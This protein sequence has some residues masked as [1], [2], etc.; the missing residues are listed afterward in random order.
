MAVA[1]HREWTRRLLHWRDFAD[2]SLF[3]GL[4][5]FVLFLALLLPIANFIYASFTFE[6]NYNEGWNVYNADRLIRGELI[7]DDNYWRVNNYPIGSFLIIAGVD[8]LFQNLLLS[9]RLV[10]LVSFA[11]IAFFAAIAIRRFGGGRTDAVFGA[12]CA[13]GFCYLVAPAWIIADD[14]QTL[15]EAVVLGALVSYIARPPDRLNLLRTAF[16]VVL[17][18][19]IKHNLVAVPVAITLDL[20]IRSPRRLLFWLASCAG[21]ATGFIGL[22]QLVAGGNFV[23]HLLSPRI[24]SWY[25]ARYHLVKY[26]RLFKFPLA[27]IALSASWLLLADRMILAVWGMISI[28]S[29]TILSGFE[30]TS[31]N[32]FQDA[33]VFLGIAA[34]V[35]MSELRKLDSSGRFASILATALPFVVAQPIVARVH[36]VAAQVYHGRALLGSASK[37]QEMFLG[38]AKY[39]ADRR[40]PAICESLLLCYV[41]GQPFILDPFNSRQYMLSGRLDQGE[42]IRRIAAREF[43]VIQ[44]RADI[45]DDPATQSC[46]ILHYRQKVDRFTDE[47]LYAIDQYYEVGRRSTFG[48]FYVPK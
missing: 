9:G 34:G 42:L 40:G 12:G 24:F 8:V 6:V 28:I 38:D 46:H 27:A 44:L 13:A 3:S 31:Y 11:A 45:C 35:M 23:D 29:A 10:A 47:V 37:R 43:A 26:L 2:T 4:C 32:M 14:P 20:A 5:Y 17:G 25:G 36:D 39:V 30:G 33:A 15:G 22:T 21:F 19:F 7:Y 48:S 18:G 41:A 16:L 1:S